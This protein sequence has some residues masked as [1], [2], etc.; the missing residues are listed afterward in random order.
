MDLAREIERKFLIPETPPLEGVRHARMRQ[1]YLATGPT[2]VRVRDDGHTRTLTCKRGDGVARTEVETT[3][4]CEQ[5]DALWPLTDGQRIDKTRYYLPFGSYTVEL[6]IFHASL[7]PL[8]V[9]EVEFKSIEDSRNFTPP[10]YFGEEL[11][12]DYRYTNSHLSIHGIPAD[13][14]DKIAGK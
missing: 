7:S 9:A 13:F 12:H 1:G 2:S 11:T 5:F 8:V 4:T 6:D 10:D 14:P 3:I